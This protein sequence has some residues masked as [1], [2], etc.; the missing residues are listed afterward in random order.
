MHSILL[1]LLALAMWMNKHNLYKFYSI[2]C[3]RIYFIN[4]NGSAS[5]L[6]PAE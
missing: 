2:I 1:L 4:V 3:R 6:L 5:G